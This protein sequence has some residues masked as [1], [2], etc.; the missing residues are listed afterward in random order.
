MK[1]DQRL[2]TIISF[3]VDLVFFLLLVNQ[4]NKPVFIDDMMM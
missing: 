4:E 2:V 1:N 3:G